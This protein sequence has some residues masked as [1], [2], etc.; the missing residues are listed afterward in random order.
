MNSDSKQGVM[1]TTTL[2]T[3]PVL[4]AAGMALIC[5]ILFHGA[6]LINFSINADEEHLVGRPHP[7]LYVLNGRWGQYL[8][9]Y[10]VLPEQVFPITSLAIC[11]SALAAS[12]VLLVKKFGIRSWQSVVVASPFFFGFPILLYNFAY[13][14]NSFAIGLGILSS[15]VALYAAETRSVA[16]FV[17]TSALLAFGISVYQSVLFFAVVVFL[18]ES[19]FA[20]ELNGGSQSTWRKWRWYASVFIGGLALYF[21]VS[22]LLLEWYKAN[23]IYVDTFIHVNALLDSPGIIVSRTLGQMWEVYSGSS[24][25]FMGQNLYYRL[26]IVVFLVTIMWHALAG[27]SHLTTAVVLLAIVFVPFLLYPIALGYMPFRT[28]LG[29]P[30]ATAVVA[31]FSTELSLDWIRRWVLLPLSLLLVVEFSAINNR[32]YYAGHWGTERD[33]LLASQIALRINELSPG[34]RTFKIAVVGS[35]PAYDDVVVPAVPFSTLGASLFSITGGNPT[36]IASFLRFVSHADFIPMNPV[37]SGANLT[38]KYQE[39]C[40]KILSFAATMPSWPVQGS[41]AQMGDIFVIKLSEPT[42]GQIQTACLNRQSLFCSRP[43]HGQP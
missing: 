19:L 11:L 32:Q 41:V 33:K 24:P 18:A 36:R 17:A 20:S 25:V 34:Q 14:N 43:S 22:Y 38:P 10:F 9:S 16:R 42:P 35:G 29:V 40:E 3:T 5:S 26:L 30:A 12:F 7:A 23:I 28:L 37:A 39:H 2:V 21:I 8:L 1:I 27:R 31:L 6:E 13:S 15:T 4:V